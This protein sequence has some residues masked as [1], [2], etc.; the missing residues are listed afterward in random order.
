MSSETI[1]AI[2]IAC[3]ERSRSSAA[4]KLREFKLTSASRRRGREC[5]AVGRDVFGYSSNKISA[6]AIRKIRFAKLFFIHRKI[7][8]KRAQAG[9]CDH[10]G[11]DSAIVKLGVYV[12]GPL[13]QNR[14]Q[15]MQLAPLTEPAI[16][17]L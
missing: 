8:R 9:E 11:P 7:G 14:L 4:S 5:F 12:H 16:D 13:S 15:E 1:C 6:Y 10:Y 2:V 17:S 3:A